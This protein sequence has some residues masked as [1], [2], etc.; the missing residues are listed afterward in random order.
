MRQVIEAAQDPV[1]HGEAIAAFP[2]Q[3]LSEQFFDRHGVVPAAL[4]FAGHF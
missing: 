2:L 3:R 4:I 1:L